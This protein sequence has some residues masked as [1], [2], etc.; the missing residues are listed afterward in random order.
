MVPSNGFCLTAISN[1][2]WRFA[3]GKI[4]FTDYISRRTG[5]SV[6]WYLTLD[7]SWSSEAAREWLLHRP[8]A[9]RVP[10]S[11]LI[12]LGGMVSVQVN[13]LKPH[14]TASA[15]SIWSVR[16]ATELYLQIRREVDVEAAYSI[17]YR[18]A[19]DALN[20]SSG[21]VVF[22]MLDVGIFARRAGQLAVNVEKFQFDPDLLKQLPQPYEVTD[23]QTEL[24]VE[25][26]RA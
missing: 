9:A 4:G 11:A 15:M 18:V 20:A 24:L 21:D 12:V 19:I 25:K 16:A 6:Q 3:V 8:E 5:M 17:L 13:A 10:G 1:N 2:G 7:S 23:P 22:A 14:E 26:S